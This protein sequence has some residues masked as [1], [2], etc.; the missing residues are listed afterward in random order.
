MSGR[1]D[2]IV[3][4]VVLVAFHLSYGFLALRSGSPTYASFDAF[5]GCVMSRQEGPASSSRGL[6]RR[7]CEYPIHP[8]H[9]FRSP[10]RSKIATPSARWL[11]D[12][13]NLGWQARFCIRV[14][15]F[16]CFISVPI[17]SRSPFSHLSPDPSQSHHQGDQDRDL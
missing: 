1:C 2:W 14:P 15:V 3:V 17:D 9:E 16:V 11:G 7:A 12:R 10:V 5:S 4:S 13:I 8:G 6:E